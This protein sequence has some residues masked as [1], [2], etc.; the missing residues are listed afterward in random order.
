MKRF[1]CIVFVL[2]C[3][4]C[5]REDTYV[6]HGKLRCVRAKMAYLMQVD[7]MGNA[8]IV[9]S[10]PIHGGEFRFRGH[11]DSPTMRFIRIGTRP[12]FDVFVENSQIEISGSLLLP[13]EIKVEGS[14]SHSEFNQ[15]QK[16]SQRISNKQNAT[17]VRLTEEK[18]KNHTAEVARLTKVYNTYPDSLL[19]YLHDFVNKKPT[20][21]GAAYFVCSLS[22]TM[23][24]KKLESVIRLFDSTLDRTP[25][26]QYLHA[27]IQLSKK[28]QVGMDAPDFQ[29]PTF[30]SDTVR[31]SDYRGKYLFLDFGASWC[32]NS[33]ERVEQLKSL[34]EKYNEKGFEILSIS[35]DDDKKIW[36]QYVSELGV[37]P[38]KQSCDLMYWSS[39]VTKYYAVSSIPYGVLV[40]DDGKIAF[41][42]PKLPQLDNYLKKKLKK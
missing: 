39:L 32:P 30:L 15:L 2:L 6:V 8:F 3:L 19:L 36:R 27:E 4:S 25:Y 18:R 22:Q 7:P 13:E 14:A 16:E 34:H 35:L 24:I 31:L 10:V 20:S 41:V 28:L 42:N 12:P 40:D 11:V 1:P 33:E 17:L 29:L 26:V 21:V 38:W 9:D 23:D 37:L 5:H